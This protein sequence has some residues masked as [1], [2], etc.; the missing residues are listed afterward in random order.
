M[1]WDAY[2]R[3][4]AAVREIANAADRQRATAD[5][6]HLLETVP[7]AAEAFSSVDE[8]LREVQMRWLR[9]LGGQLDRLGA[10]GPVG[11]AESVVVRAWTE[12][13]RIH[14]GLRV[15]LDRAEGHPALAT[16]R[17]TETRLL[18]AAAGLPASEGERLRAAGQDATVLPEPD[19][20]EPRGL[21]ARLREALAA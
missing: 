4:A 8:L 16:A 6:D 12:T 20:D 9:T 14:P 18:A 3:R 10:E 5:P 17:A 1:T 7:Q 19:D 11:D 13:A 2:H 15:V 21:I